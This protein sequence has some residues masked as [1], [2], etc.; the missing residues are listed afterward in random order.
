M[1]PTSWYIVPLTH[2]TRLPDGKKSVGFPS[3]GWERYKHEKFEGNSQC[4][5]VITGEKSNLTILDC[6]TMETYEALKVFGDA[7]YKV[8]TARGMHMYFSY[9]PN[10]VRR[11]LNLANFRLDVQ[12]D[13]ALIFLPDNADGYSPINSPADIG[14]MPPA[15]ASF[16]KSLSEL[17]KETQTEEKSSTI[18][19]TGTPLA[20]IIEGYL[21]S[22]LK[23]PA[24]LWKRLTPKS[25]RTQNKPWISPKEIGDG[26]GS[27]YLSKVGAILASDPSVDEDMF[28]EAL[29]AI[30]D[31]WDEPM[32]SDR[33]H[34]TIINPIKRGQFWRFDEDWDKGKFSFRSKTNEYYLIWYDTSYYSWVLFN[35]TRQRIEYFTGVSSFADHVSALSGE[36]ATK[37][38][39]QPH[40]RSYYTTFR[41]D[42]NEQFFE[43]DGYSYFNSYMPTQYMLT[44]RSEDTITDGRIPWTI[45]RLFRSLYGRQTRYT[46]RFLAR[47]FKTF[48]YSPVTFVLYDPDGGSGKNLHIEHVLKP[49]VGDRHFANPREEAYL[50]NH[51]QW[52]AYC[53]IGHHDEY[54]NKKQVTGINKKYTGTNSH[55]IRG[56]GKDLV[57]VDNYYTPFFTSNK[58]PIEATNDKDRRLMAVRPPKPLTEWRWFKGDTIL[59]D[60]SSELMDFCKFLHRLTPLSKS[61]YMNPPM[62]D[63]KQAI[64]ENSQTLVDR[65]V[66]LVKD[67]NWEGLIEMADSPT[68]Q[69]TIFEYA[70]RGFLTHDGLMDLLAARAGEHAPSAHKLATAM[71]TIG[72][73]SPSMVGANKKVYKV[74]GLET[75]LAKTRPMEHQEPAGMT[76]NLGVRL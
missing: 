52:L 10:L 35:E 4:A 27:E 63:M 71:R 20:Y 28:T 75:Y 44:L 39:I 14:P 21:S 42:K 30:N 70:A 32:S 5:A 68:I 55:S 62:T 67:A 49:I 72:G 74:R 17:K 33:L 54:Q 3:D 29:E 18:R 8:K 40:L 7:T 56:M 45:L 60:L 26:E 47:K 69:D 76:I 11:K 57:Q 66:G 22:T 25:F 19:L 9:E 2:I 48:D 12:T 51:N 43:E 23:D 16:V 41:P 6:D 1:I 34:T 37:K 36:N 50:E 58:V 64:I 24:T 61:E 53:M 59:E 15:L 13:E 73:Y 65:V 31:E 46:L 38:D